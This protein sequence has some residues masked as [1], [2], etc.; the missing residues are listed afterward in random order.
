MIISASTAVERLGITA[1]S[2]ELVNFE[3]RLKGIEELIRNYTKNNFH[4]RMIRSEESLTFVSSTKTITG[5]DFLELGFRAG[6]TIE[7]SYA[8]LNRGLFTVASVTE[9]SLV[10]NESLQDETDEA[11]ITKVLYPSDVV[12]G[13]LKL[14]AYENQMEGKMG[15]KSETIS[16]YSVTYFDM[17]SAESIEGYPA[18]LMK[19]L[20]KYKRV[21]RA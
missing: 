14:L 11:M 1:I 7:V 19:F 12:E 9:S 4:D 17:T 21:R 6:D 13:V 3:A 20:A 5:D 2:E 16:R 18:S 15:I 8:L 10:V